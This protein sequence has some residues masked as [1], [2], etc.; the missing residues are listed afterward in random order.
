ML[1]HISARRVRAWFKNGPDSLFRVFDAQ[2]TQCF[3]NSCGMM[4]KIIDDRDAPRN[5][6]HLHA[7]FNA[8][9]AVKSRLNLVV[10]EA[11][12]L[13]ASDYGEGVTDVQFSQKIGMKLKTGDFKFRGC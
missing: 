13:G 12:M 10:F 2:G 8:F 11:A 4:S 6:S 3:A 7:A 1:E 9:E 5:A